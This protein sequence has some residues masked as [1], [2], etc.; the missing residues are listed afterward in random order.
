MKKGVWHMYSRVGDKYKTDQGDIWD[1]IAL[2]AF[3]DEHA[4]SD[5]IDANWDYIYQD[6][7]PANVILNV[8]ATASVEINFRPTRTIPNLSELLPW[9]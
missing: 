8:P 1:I 5:M 4:M 3:G 7:F 6:V 9:R 2:R